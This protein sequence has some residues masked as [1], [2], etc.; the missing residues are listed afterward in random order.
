[1]GSGAPNLLSP[2]SEEEKEKEESAGSPP[3]Q[4]PLASASLDSDRS[5]KRRLLPPPRARPGNTLLIRSLSEP[6]LIDAEAPQGPYR[7]S[8]AP[9]RDILVPCRGSILSQPLSVF[10]YL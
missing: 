9:Y 3:G 10:I 1:M 8:I 5:R 4:L 7:D 6:A 2:H